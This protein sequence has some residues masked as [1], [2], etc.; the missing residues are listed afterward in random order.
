MQSVRSPVALLILI[1]ATGVCVADPVDQLQTLVDQG[2]VGGARGLLAGLQI[3]PEDLKARYYTGRLTRQDRV[4]RAHFR[5]IA[6]F[7]DADYADDAQLELAESAYADPQGLYR[8]A[9]RAFQK[10]VDAYPDSPHIPLALY[11]IGRTYQITVGG[12]DS[13]SQ[14]DS[15]RAR[16]Q[17][18]IRRFPDTQTARHAAVALVD[19]DLQAG[20]LDAVNRDAKG[21]PSASVWSGESGLYARIG[22]QTLSESEASGSFWVQVGAFANRGLLDALVNRLLPTWHVQLVEAGRVTLVRV[23]PYTTRAKAE[24]TSNHIGRVESV[25]C[26]IIQD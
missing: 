2:D 18:V 7:A 13:G 8:T 16:Y 19:A 22:R 9:R 3:H 12:S 24:Q 17:E 21:L 20:D 10:L 14:L 1:L 5:H 15:A 11:R 25:T 4:A 6:R 26:Q 23:G